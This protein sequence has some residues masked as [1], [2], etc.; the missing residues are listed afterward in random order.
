MSAQLAAQPAD[1]VVPM[2]VAEQVRVRG[3]VQGVGF[4]P[5]VW[6]IAREL[7]VAGS[8][9]NDAQ[10]VLIVAVAEAAVLDALVQR[11]RDD[12][13]PLARIETIERTRI[14][15]P[16]PLPRDFKID[17]SQHG[18]T[19]TAVAA[20]AAI[21]AECTAEIFDPFGRRFRYPLTNCTRPPTITSSFSICHG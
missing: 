7:Q 17:P 21:C 14:A 1:R 15:L 11:L 12:A 2:S 20:D 9:I 5:T 6:R 13:P 18:A 8:I 3:T 10:G 19:H 4:R 16:A